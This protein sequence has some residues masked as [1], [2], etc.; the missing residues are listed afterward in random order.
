MSKTNNQDIY[1]P[2]ELDLKALLMSGEPITFLVGAGISIDPPS[3]LLS[4]WKMMEDIVRFGGSPE[5]VEK[6]M[7]IENL[8]YEYLIE[9]FRDYYDKELKL[10][11]YFEEATQPNVIHRFLAQQIRKGQFVMTTNFDTLIERAVGLDEPKLQI[12]ITREDFENYSNPQA[13]LAEGLLA[14]YKLHGSSTNAKTGADT[15]DSVITTLD[16]LGKHKEG[17]FFTVETFKRPLFAKVGL[18]RT[19]LVMGYSGGDD[20]DIIPTLRQMKGLK[21]VIWLMHEP[22]GGNR[23]KNYRLRSLVKG[24]SEMKGGLRREDQILQKL[25][26]LGTLEVIKVCAHTSSIIAPLVERSTEIHDQP[27]H[28]MS[29]WL[30]KNVNPPPEGAPEVFSASVFYTYGFYNDALQYY[31]QAYEIF[32]RLGNESGMALQLGNMGNVCRVTGEPQ[33]ALDYFQQAYEINE[34]LDN[35]AGMGSFL[36]SM[37][38]IYQETGE[39]QKAL[40]HYQQAYEIDERLGN[41][42]GK[43]LQLANMGGLYWGIGEPQ[44]ALEHLHRAYKIFEGLG[45]IAMMAT[46]LGNMG[47]IYQNIGEPQKALEHYQQAYEIFERLGNLTMQTIQ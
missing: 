41:E 14:V 27:T 4:A 22:Q 26:R 10:L 17:E 23:V 2:Y 25:G 11:K 34:R 18:E 32:Q 21:R 3:G 24:S 45:N 44:K 13:N 38:V 16:A 8:R 29:A 43:A 42:S 19:L 36:G 1:E 7:S 9:L 39:P 5:A 40:E 31:Q 15:R 6:I 20:F 37:A 12:V 30:L 47:L 33:K 35:E 46:V 28:D